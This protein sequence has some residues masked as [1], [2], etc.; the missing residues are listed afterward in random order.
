LKG[1]ADMPK[2]FGGIVGWL[3][4]TVVVVVVGLWIVNRVAF[5]K[6]ITGGN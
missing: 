4:S 5:L 3:V 1:F 6:N 2:S